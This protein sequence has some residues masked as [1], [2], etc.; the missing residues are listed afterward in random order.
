M[1]GVGARQASPNIQCAWHSH[2]ASPAPIKRSVRAFVP[3]HN[4]PSAYRKILVIKKRD[5]FASQTLR[6]QLLPHGTP[7][8]E[9][10]VRWCDWIPRITGEARLAPTHNVNDII[11]RYRRYTI[12]KADRSSY[13]DT[14]CQAPTGIH[15]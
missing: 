3:R 6:L 14:M 5:Y 10:Y 2:K 1:T 11:N 4:V 9:G 13:L 8:K 7:R 12:N 15:Y